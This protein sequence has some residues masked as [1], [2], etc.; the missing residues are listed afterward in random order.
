MQ[1]LVLM[2]YNMR[3][4][5]AFC[6]SL[7]LTVD[8]E[9]VW[10][11]FIRWNGTE[12]IV[13]GANSEHQVDFPAVSLVSLLNLFLL[14]KKELRGEGTCPQRIQ[15]TAPWHIVFHGGPQTRDHFT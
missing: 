3:V 6:F 8:M 12:L 7:L 15:P 9:D 4:R 13:S 10:H 2:R 5:S 11:L 1:D 14:Q